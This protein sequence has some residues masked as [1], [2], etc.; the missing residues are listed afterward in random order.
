MTDM[1]SSISSTNFTGLLAAFNVILLHACPPLYRI[2]DG[3]L[4]GALVES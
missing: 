2:C 1:A 3:N 4:L